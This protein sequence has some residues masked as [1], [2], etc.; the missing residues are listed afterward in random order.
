M[1]S[2][3]QGCRAAAVDREEPCTRRWQQASRLARHRSLLGLIGIEA[4]V[5]S[6]DEVYELVVTIAAGSHDVDEI[7]G[8]L[9]S[10]IKAA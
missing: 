5:A 3:D 7:A 1:C 8:M 4:T 2:T 10:A 9:R 6:N